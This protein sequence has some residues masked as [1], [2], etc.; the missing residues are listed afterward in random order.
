ME[1]LWEQTWEKPDFP[2]QDGDMNTDVLIIGGGMAGI[3][4]AHQL[5]CAGVPYVLA[6]A[7]T[8]CSVEVELLQIEAIHLINSLLAHAI[9]SVL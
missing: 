8:I 9:F 1:S 6:E 7:E 4:C 3:L 5:H 2:S